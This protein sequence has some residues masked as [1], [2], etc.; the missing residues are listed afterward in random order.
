MLHFSE[1]QPFS[2]TLP[3]YAYDGLSPLI[4]QGNGIDEARKRV[5]FP[6]SEYNLEIAHIISSQI[7]LGRCVLFNTIAPS[8][9]WVSSM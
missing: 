1:I 6:L 4:F 9:M 8:H 7:L 2:I 5:I 3:H